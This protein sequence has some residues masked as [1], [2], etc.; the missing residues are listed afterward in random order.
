MS[1]KMDK[2]SYSW[3]AKVYLTATVPGL[4]RNPGS[5]AKLSDVPGCLLEISTGRGTLSGYEL[6]EAEGVWESYR[7][8]QLTGFPG[9]DTNGN[10]RE[11]LASGETWRKWPD[12]RKDRD[13]SVMTR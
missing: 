5:A 6:A 2:E 11:G 12:R 13:A 7:P 1:I 8:S 10:N 3:T 9:H 4:L